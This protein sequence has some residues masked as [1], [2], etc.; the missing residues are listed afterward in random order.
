M[1]EKMTKKCVRC[2]RPCQPGKAENPKAR[3]FRRA[4]AGLCPDCAVTHFLLSPDLEALRI[5]L[6][7][8]GIETLKH[9]AIQ[10]QFAEILRVGGSEMSPEEIDWDRVVDKWNMPFPKGYKP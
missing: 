4:K 3:P 5:S 1:A 2:G 7:R 10:A 6:L 9:P 8:E